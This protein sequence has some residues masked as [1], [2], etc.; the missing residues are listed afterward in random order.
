MVTWFRAVQPRRW[1]GISRFSYYNRAVFRRIALAAVVCCRLATA[2]SQPTH[3]QESQAA[4]YPA[5][6]KTAAAPGSSVQPDSTELEAIKKV[7]AVYPLVA[8]Q[9]QIQGQVIVRVLVSETGDVEQAEALSGDPMLAPAA[10]EA[11]KKWKFKPFIKDGKAV[12]VRGRIPFDFAFSDKV[13][14]YGGSADRTAGSDNRS[15][16][17]VAAGT[18]PA[19]G[20]SPEPDQKPQALPDKV[21]VSQGVSQGLL[22]HKVAPVYPA[23]ARAN[24]IQGTV[25]L[26]A[27]ISK[28]G[29]IK[30]L[31]PI[32]GQEELVGAAIA[33]VQQWRYRPY[34]LKGQP[35]EVE[36]QITV[37]FTL[38]R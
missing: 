27:T 16:V 3:Q 13:M 28:E 37:N 33:A 9:R 11:V 26:R 34:V 10:L 20:S 25:I 1:R 18:Q 14:E 21:R 30:N 8:R 5:A 29:R 36:T 4:G 31:T 35:V 7:S 22:I 38:N 6:E 32:S 23:V 15:T 24:D 12:K 19:S 2:Q 17:P